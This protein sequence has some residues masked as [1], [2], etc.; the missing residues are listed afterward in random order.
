ML[1][2]I[3][4]VCFLFS[5]PLFIIPFISEQFGP[6]EISVLVG[7]GIAYLLGIMF[8]HLANNYE[9]VRVSIILGL[10]FPIF[11]VGSFFLASLVFDFLFYI[12]LFDA[13]PLAEAIPVVIMTAICIRVL[14]SWLAQ[15]YP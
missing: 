12:E 9:N 5:A 2:L 10:T 6:R 1:A 14:G 13:P 7:S 8:F 11:I 4:S 15:K 3:C